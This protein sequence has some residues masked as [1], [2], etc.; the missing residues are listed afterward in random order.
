MPRKC[1][2]AAD[3]FCYICDQVTFKSQKLRFTRIIMKCYEKYFGCK[4]GDFDKKWAPHI[5]C[6]SCVR[7]LN[8]WKK[9]THDMIFAIPMV[10]YIIT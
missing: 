4:S 6:V 1:L 7:L 5:C 2:N 8:G 3:N 10:C 9:G